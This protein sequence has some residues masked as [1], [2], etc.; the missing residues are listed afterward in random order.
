MKRIIL[1]RKIPKR[2][3]RTR[4]LV[5]DGKWFAYK[6]R[7]SQGQSFLTHNDVKTGVYYGFFSS[8]LSL[9]K[10][11]N[12]NKTIICWDIGDE[13]KRRNVY[14]DYKRKRNTKPLTELD[15]NKQFK[16]EYLNLVEY[17]KE[18]GFGGNYI[19]GYESDDLMAAYCLQNP[20]EEIFLAT[21]DEDM[22]QCLNDHVTIYNND[23]KI[24]KT[25]KWFQKEYGIDPLDWNMVKAIS[26]CSSDNVKGIEGI[27]EKTALKYLREECSEKQLQ[28]IKDNWK[29]VE[30]CLA[31][32]TLPHP[33]LQ[34]DFIF[35]FTQSN[36]DV[37][38]FISWCQRFGMKDF[39]NNI[40]DFKLYFTKNKM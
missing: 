6:S 1:K 17:C 28:K 27:G 34:N 11:L 15:L 14:P 12:T 4:T 10:K 25:D 29:T 30:E 13:S 7:F 19:L 37:D 32:V 9:A 20:N 3:E 16:E 26:G 38:K 36:I 23:D 2:E 35:G 21:K 31:V 33:D 5:V 40:S 22:Y 24:K 39:L 18:I 8:I